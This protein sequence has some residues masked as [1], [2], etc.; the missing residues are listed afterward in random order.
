MNNISIIPTKTDDKKVITFE[1]ILKDWVPDSF[2]EDFGDHISTHPEK[3]KLTVCLLIM[4]N[5]LIIGGAILGKGVSL[6]EFDD[7]NKIAKVKSYIQSVRQNLS[8]FCI[9]EDFR[10]KGY[11][12]I[13]LKDINQIFPE[14]W[15]SASSELLNFYKTNNYEIEIPITSSED[16]SLLISK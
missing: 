7:P 15:L 14:N 9:K 10:N 12:S 13:A 2:S 6:N 1:R 4:D 16:R 8:Y 5:R 11:G 3:D